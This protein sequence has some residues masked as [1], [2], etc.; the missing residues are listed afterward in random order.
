[1]IEQSSA[2]PTVPG[3]VTFDGGQVGS[4]ALVLA[5]G[6]IVMFVLALGDGEGVTDTCRLVLVV[7]FIKLYTAPLLHRNKICEGLSGRSVEQ[8][9]QSIHN[10]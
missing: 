7:I 8:S 5:S 6:A 4:G 10:I 9:I 2:A 1:M 3:R